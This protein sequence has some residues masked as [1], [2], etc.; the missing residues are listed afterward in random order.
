MY[1]VTILMILGEKAL[2]FTKLEY[3]EFAI[4]NNPC[5]ITQVGLND[6]FAS[7]NQEYDH[8]ETFFKEGEYEQIT[9]KV[10]SENSGVQLSLPMKE[11]YPIHKFDDLWTMGICIDLERTFKPKR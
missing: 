11:T 7:F 3:A 6:I 5:K 2:Y 10:M 9:E 1:V 4:K 8:V